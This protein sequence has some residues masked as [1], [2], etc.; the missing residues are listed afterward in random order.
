MN[1]QSKQAKIPTPERLAD[2]LIGSL[3]GLTAI[4]NSELR[5]HV[6]MLI[7]HS[8]ALGYAA[9]ASAGLVA[10]MRLTLAL[11]RRRAWQ[12]IKFALFA[13]RE[14]LAVIVRK[15]ERHSNQMLVPT[16]VIQYPMRR[17]V[18]TDDVPVRCLHG[19]GP[20]ALRRQAPMITASIPIRYRRQAQ[21][22]KLSRARFIG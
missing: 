20:A 11:S 2:N 9:G 7:N 22:R 1:N 13:L 19:A 5:R 16:R 12:T 14:R 3:G 10:R 6:V 15:H 4:E 18:I 21:R 17:A 8:Y